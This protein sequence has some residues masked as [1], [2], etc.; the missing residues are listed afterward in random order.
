MEEFIKNF[1]EFRQ[2]LNAPITEYTFKTLLND[3]DKALKVIKDK[4]NEL[5]LNNNFFEHE[6]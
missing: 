6:K 5:G 3:G 2:F 4:F 1:Q